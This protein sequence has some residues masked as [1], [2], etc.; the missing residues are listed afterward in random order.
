MFFS[1]FLPFFRKLYFPYFPRFYK[2]KRGE[3]QNTGN[4]LAFSA[5]PLMR[6]IQGKYR[7]YRTVFEGLITPYEPGEATP[8]EAKHEN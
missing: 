4:T 6:E 2:E 8:G 3:I 1:L 5:F 7:K